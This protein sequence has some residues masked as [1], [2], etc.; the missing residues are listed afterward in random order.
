M[1]KCNIKC[2]ITRN[3]RSLSSNTLSRSYSLSSHTPE[4]VDKGKY[5]RVMV[6]DKLTK[7]LKERGYVTL[8]RPILEH[9]CMV[10]DPHLKSDIKRI[11]ALK[12]IQ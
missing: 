10:L 3:A 5:L 2:N 9:G 1:F 8:I 12:T 11:K 4:E 6:T 7:I